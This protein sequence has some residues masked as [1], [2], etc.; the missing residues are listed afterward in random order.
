MITSWSI[1]R[2][3]IVGFALGPIALIIIGIIAYTN[4]NR[5]LATETIM[6]DSFAVRNALH[7]VELDLVDA[8]TGQRGYLLTGTA[9]YLR[10]YEAARDS[11]KAGMDVLDRTV[12][13]EP[14]QQARAA[15]IRT[16]GN[17]KLAELA[18]SLT[19]A[20]QHGL[21]A[22]RALVRDNRGE[23]VMEHIRSIYLDALAEQRKIE[24]TRYVDDQRAA[25]WAK[26]AILYG[27]VSSGRAA[28]R[29][30]RAAESHDR[31]D[32]SKKP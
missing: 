11:V 22:A 20:R 23:V 16:L 26:A 12:A 30:R 19:V 17:E 10:P 21:A 13:S 7:R 31:V 8:E 1:T 4:T 28:D 15:Q 25:D 3:I 6:N 27:T 18:Q 14:Q 2:K 24:A 9:S 29:G 5:M 32:R